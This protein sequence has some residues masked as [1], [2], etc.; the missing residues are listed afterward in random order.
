[1]KHHC[2]EY[3]TKVYLWGKNLK[4]MQEISWLQ[5][6]GME[7]CWR[8]YMDFFELKEL[9]APHCKTQNFKTMIKQSA[10]RKFGHNVP[11]LGLTPH[12][13]LKRQ[14]WSWIALSYLICLTVQVW[15]H[16]PSAFSSNWRNIFVGIHLTQ[17]KRWETLLGPEKSFVSAL[18]TLSSLAEVW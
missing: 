16:A 10:R 13:T 5:I 14:L 18:T 17:M 4:P 1:M 15:H 2:M 6:R 12:E 9:I 8:S 11:I 7:G 3:I